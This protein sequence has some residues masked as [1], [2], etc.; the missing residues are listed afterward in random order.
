MSEKHENGR[1]GDAPDTV[2][3]ARREMFSSLGLLALGGGA[4]ALLGCDPSRKEGSIEYVQKALGSSSVQWCANLAEQKTL[5]GGS[6]TSS[7]NVLIRAGY[8]DPDDGGGGIFRWS[9][10][11]TVDDTVVD[12]KNGV[13]VVPTVT[14]RTGCW[15][16]LFDGALNVKWF[17][18][19]GKSSFGDGTPTDSAAAFRAC[20]ELSNLLR[21]TYD[22][23]PLLNQ[24]KRG[25]PPAIYVPPGAYLMTSFIQTDASAAAGKVSAVLYE[26]QTLYGEGASSVILWPGASGPA[27]TYGLVQI[28]GNNVTVRHLTF[29]GQNGEESGANFQTPPDEDVQN[30]AVS[31]YGRAGA[32]YVAASTFVNIEISDCVFSNLFGF[33]A[34]GG[35]GV[36][37]FIRFERN[38]CRYCA[39]GCNIS[40]GNTDFIGNTF[41]SS[42]GIETA[43]SDLKICDNRFSGSTGVVSVNNGAPRN[44][45]ISGNTFDLT[46]AGPLAGYAIWVRDATDSVIVNNSIRNPR[47]F[48]IMVGTPDNVATKRSIVSN[49]TVTLDADFHPA[50]GDQQGILVVNCDS[51]I[52]HG[53]TLRGNGNTHGTQGIL[54]QGATMTTVD[55]NVIS[56]FDKGIV[57]SRWDAQHSYCSNLSF[58]DN[59]VSGCLVGGVLLESLDDGMFVNNEFRNNAVVNFQSDATTAN[60]R[61]ISNQIDAPMTIAS[62]GSV[63]MNASPTSLKLGGGNGEIQAAGDLLFQVGT[64]PTVA[65][66][67]ATIADGETGLLLRRN[68][69]GSAELKRV[70]LGAVVNIGGVNYRSLIVAV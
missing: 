57:A 39:N 50:P 32:E 7:P 68:H 48:G 65:Q 34:Q 66:L 26:G 27:V 53:N 19:K 67:S 41:I 42:E 55:A 3:E 63:V 21:D 54:L 56:G 45:V 4:A 36:S 2:L 38:V 22:S 20:I 44:V 9:G 25:G 62:A 5:V 69:Q 61:L 18:A 31:V 17:G 30:S 43:G 35:T 29:K 51:V 33:S 47:S 11:T 14:P 6:T 46:G 8:Y 16:R 70:V 58:A 59:R 37:K 28:K 49:N 60:L 1:E 23:E 40:T 13:I 52:V 15:V 24:L 12:P 64:I 10:D